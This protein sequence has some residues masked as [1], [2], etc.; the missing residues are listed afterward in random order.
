MKHINEVVCILYA[1]AYSTRVKNKML[2]KFSDSCLFEIAIQKLINSKFIPRENKYIA[3]YD[4]ELIDIVKKYD[5]KLLIR[6]KRSAYHESGQGDEKI[7]YAYEWWDKLPN[8]FKYYF[9]FNACQP[10]LKT[11][12]IDNSIKQFLNSENRS[13]V[14]AIKMKD[15]F[16]D[17]DGNL[18]KKHFKQVEAGDFCFNTK[19]VSTT[20]KASHTL[21]I[22]RLE[23]IGNDIWLG[24]F[25]KNDPELFFI[26]EIEAFDIDY[27]HEFDI[28]EL[29]YQ[30]K[31]KLNY[32]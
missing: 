2:R 31:D 21:Q 12:T 22:G 30:N 24:S 14:S 26:D 6:S 20:Y 28:C 15:Y 7:K 16:W 19:Y 32:S 5:I 1:H 27:P 17:D 18:D 8:H 11:E 3:V 4:P 10:M 29:I 25:K 13:L 9:H 23:D